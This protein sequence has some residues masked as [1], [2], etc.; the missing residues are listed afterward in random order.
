MDHIS[1]L[2]E[3]SINGL[4]I[5]PGDT[6]LDGTLGSGG[7]SASVCGRYPT[8]SV[9]GIDRDQ[10]AIDRTTVLFKNKGYKA[11]FILGEFRN[12]ET[13]LKSKGINQ[14]NRI[15]FDFGLSS[16]QIDT[17]GRG[18]TFT[19]DEPLL[20][21]MEVNKDGVTA[22]DV[23]NTWSEETL[24]TIIYGFGE[25]R[26]SRRI[27]KAI[28]T[29]RT[30]EPITRTTH[31]VD[32]I[33]G[34]VPA[35]YRNGKINPATRTF[36]AIRI[37]V[38]QELDNINEG[39]NSAWNILAPGGRIACISFHSLEDRI[40]KQF[41]NTKKQEGAKIITKKPITPTETEINSNPRSRSS[42]LRIIEK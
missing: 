8:V 14:V 2:L 1:V 28:V 11:T 16:P 19:K 13:L 39:L 4:D 27:A 24:A 26:Y 36:Q 15:L 41:F 21:T 6:F 25:E 7:H 37:A 3:E 34:A 9:I 22:T 17:S 12:L 38:N 35:S 29:A 31:L 32:I 40:V 10:A 23:V 42:K 5:K 33:R 30:V 20:M 18:F